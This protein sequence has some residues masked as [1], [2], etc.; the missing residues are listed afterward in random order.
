MSKPKHVGILSMCTRVA[1]TN[2]QK[3]AEL[4]EKARGNRTTAAFAEA[5]GIHP[6]TMS[7]ILNARFK[8]NLSD[9]VIAAIAVNS[10]NC[11]T[12]AFR[13]LLDAHGLVIPAAEG[14]SAA[15]QDRLY[16]EYL[17]Q[18]RSSLEMSHK[19]KGDNFEQ[20][21]A[22]KEAIRT[23]VQEIIQNYLIREGYRVARGDR[24]I[25]SGTELYSWYADFVLETNALESEGI[26]K[27]AFVI[28]E[29]V[30][31]RFMQEIS[32]FAGLAY[33][34]RP[35]QKGYRITLITMDWI[36]FYEVRSELRLLGPIYDSISVL[37]V[38]T[39]YGRVEAE[40]VID[41]ECETA[42]VMP[43]G[44]DDSEI[45]WQE[46]YGVPDDA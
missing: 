3:I 40:Y 45:D 1:P 26:D 22:R 2:M 11:T 6:A 18:V 33:F 20:S 41:R 34:G 36:T 24:E 42:K 14:K 32:H 46:V 39:R 30:G 21:G 17:N 44:K 7:R 12:A 31:P 5:C 19:T 27:W 9:D 10:V 4:T 37:L 13:E 28:S 38:N 43:A 16:T 8:K 23:R 35:A 15:E 29:V 25:E